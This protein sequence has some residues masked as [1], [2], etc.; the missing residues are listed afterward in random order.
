MELLEVT[1]YR[2]KCKLLE[3]NAREAQA[4]QALNLIR[5]AQI[6]ALREAGL[7]PTIRYVLEDK[8]LTATPVDPQ[9]ENG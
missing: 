6:T 8:T 5:E 2:L 4:V 9:S 3:L 1:Y 7:D